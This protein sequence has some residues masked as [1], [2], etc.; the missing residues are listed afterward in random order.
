[1]IRHEADRAAR[2]ADLW[3]RQIDNPLMC[4]P[5]NLVQIRLGCGLGLEV[6]NMQFRWRPNHPKLSAWFD[7]IATRPSF[8]GTTPPR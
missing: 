4:G 6:R 3:E 1:V 7:R 5:L 8:A 2:M